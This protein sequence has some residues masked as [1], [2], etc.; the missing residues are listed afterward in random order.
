M[1]AD[2]GTAGLGGQRG[3]AW[4]FPGAPPQNSALEVGLVESW[5]GQICIISMLLIDVND[6][7]I[8]G[9]TVRERHRKE[10]EREKGKRGR[11]REEGERKM[12]LA[13][14]K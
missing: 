10:G 1:R 13:V 8:E 6:N 7:T 4:G 14:T 9:N 11:E 5:G 2:L 12:C 3:G